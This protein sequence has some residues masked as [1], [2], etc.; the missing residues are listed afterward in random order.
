MLKPGF[1]IQYP[2][3]VRESIYSVEDV[4]LD[5]HVEK[6]THNLEDD[7]SLPDQMLFQCMF[8]LLEVDE[9][10]LGVLTSLSM[11]DEL[12]S[13]LEK[14]ECQHW[15]Q[16]DNMIINSK[17]ILGSLESDALDFLL[18]HIS[19]KLCLEPLLES[20]D[21]FRELD[22]ISMMES[23]QFNEN[24]EY[25]QVMADGDCILSMSSVIFEDF[26]MPDVNSSKL[27]EALFST[28]T[29]IESVTC[30][31]MFRED[32]NFKNFNELIISQELALIDDAFKSLPIPVFSNYQNIR[33]V[34]SAVLEEILSELKEK[35]LSASDGIY[36][37]WHLLE[38]DK[39]SCKI[40]CC[41]QKMFNEVDSCNIDFDLVSSDDEKLVF[42]FIFSDGASTGPNMEGCEESLNIDFVGISTLAGHLKGVSSDKLRDN[43]S[44]KPINTEQSGEKKAERASLFFKSMSEFND[45]DFFLNP[46]K[47]VTRKNGESGVNESDTIAISSNLMATG[48][49]SVIK[50]Q[51]WDI[52]LYKVMLSDDI[53]AL[54]DIFRKSYLDIVRN[55]TELNSFI[56]SDDFK[57]LSLPKQQLMD[58]INKKMLQKA[59]AHGDENSM[60]FV[61]LCA[62]KQMAWYTCFYGIHTAHLYVEKLCK[63]ED[64]FKSRLGSLQSLIADADGKVDKE[65]IRSHPSLLVI[66]GILQSN[67]SQSSLKVL[68]LAEQAFWWSLKRLVM[69]MGLSCNELQN[70]YTHV[71]QPDITNVSQFANAKMDDLPVSDCLLVSHE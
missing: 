4:A 41:H 45:L 23:S 5:Y 70:F 6:K 1:A 68:I 9:I 3:E 35:P 64:C 27:F 50:L 11:E 66:Q 34:Y 44:P 22:F 56:A 42:D 55:E 43:E 40:F 54:I 71:D 57:L 19:S 29:T 25:H 16:K 13:V 38:R 33:S 49:S 30:D 7:G 15:T 67:T 36:L 65:I 61:T 63:S 47:V 46:Q 31:W 28:Q 48:F 26:V 8:P 60:A 37:D 17:E 2:S 12:L 69:S 53:V 52:M 21:M 59:T 20:M 18:D 39:C 62:I 58:C 24:S 32:M 14:S 10:S 51:Q